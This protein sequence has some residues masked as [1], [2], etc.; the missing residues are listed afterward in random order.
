MVGDANSPATSIGSK[1]EAALVKDGECLVAD[2]HAL[3]SVGMAVPTEGAAEEGSEPKSAPTL[4]WRMVCR[5][6]WWGSRRMSRQAR[7]LPLW[8]WLRGAQQ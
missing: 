8:W 5:G 3:A 4:R 1:V 2:A 7:A 6:G